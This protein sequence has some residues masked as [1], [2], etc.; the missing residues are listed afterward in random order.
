MATFTIDQIA[1]TRTKTTLKGSDILEL[2]IKDGGVDDEKSAKVSIDDLNG[3]ST[4]LRYKCLLSQNAPIASKTSGTVIIGQIWTIETFETGDNFS[5]WELISGTANTTGAVYRALTTAP[6]TWTNGSDLSYDG[7][8]YIV[9]TNADGD[10]APFVNTLGGEPIYSYIDVGGFSGTLVGAFPIDK[11]IFK[12]P[13]NINGIENP[14]NLIAYRDSDDEFQ[15][16][17]G[18]ENVLTNGR[19]YYTPFEIEVYP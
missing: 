10:F 6:T 7:S 11:A 16:N 8:P 5:N 15:I 14:D 9:S 12:I 3:G 17:T 2:Q 18:L 4:P 1:I 13:Y 19:L